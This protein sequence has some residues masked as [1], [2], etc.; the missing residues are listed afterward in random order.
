MHCWSAP[1]E[2]IWLVQK[3]RPAASACRFRKSRYCCFTK[4]SVVVIGFGLGAAP[5]L[6]VICGAVSVARLAAPAAVIT[7][8]RSPVSTVAGKVK[9]ASSLP[10]KSSDR[11][12]PATITVVPTV[13]LIA[14][15]ALLRTPVSETRRTVGTCV[16]V[17]SLVVTKNG[18]GEHT[19]E[20]VMLHTFARPNGPFVVV[21][22]SG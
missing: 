4:K 10:G 7:I 3:A 5:A 6:I 22:I 19:A 2:L 17:P 13:T 11:A 9:S 20:F 18:S 16:P 14:V 21:N 15:V 8:G 12:A 1:H